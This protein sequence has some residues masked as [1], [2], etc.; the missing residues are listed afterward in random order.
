MVR[1]GKDELRE[2]KL[3]AQRI[4]EIWQQVERSSRKYYV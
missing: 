2:I 3:S 4:G 1:S